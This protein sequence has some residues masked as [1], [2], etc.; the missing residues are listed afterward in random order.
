LV[1]V[2]IALTMG[3]AYATH[4]GGANTIS[5]ADIQN[6]AVTNPKIAAQTI[7]TGRLADGAVTNAK[8]APESITNNRIAPDAVNSGRL[9]DGAVITR[10]LADGAVNSAKVLDNSLTG[11]DVDE[12]TLA[13]VNAATVDGLSAAPIGLKTNGTTASPVEVLDLGGLILRLECVNFDFFEPRLVAATTSNDTMIR[14]RTMPD[15][16]GANEVGR[17]TDD[18]FDTGAGDEKTLYDG[19]QGS[20]LINY[21]TVGGS[22]VTVQY[23]VDGIGTSVGGC[24]ISGTAIQGFS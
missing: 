17:I 13:E 24:T 1:A 4:P 11:T 19:S 14:S 5:T 20:G 21:R 15:F 16:P 23:M 7:Q 12:S 2:F 18:D 22:N 8:I 10:K 9:A 6:Q 3:T